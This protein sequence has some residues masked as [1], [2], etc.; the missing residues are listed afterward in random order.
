MNGCSNGICTSVVGLSLEARLSEARTLQDSSLTVM[1][2]K[3]VLMDQAL[4]RLNNV[5]NASGTIGAGADGSGNLS[6]PESLQ[7][8]ED[9]KKAREALMT[10][11][12]EFEGAKSYADQ[13]Q[14]FYDASLGAGWNA[15]APETTTTT[16]VPAPDALGLLAAQANAT[17]SAAAASLLLASASASANGS[18][19]VRS[20]LDKD[21]KADGARLE[22]EEAPILLLQDEQ[23]IHG[24]PDKKFT[25]ASSAGVAPMPPPSFAAMP[26]L[27]EDTGACASLG[28]SPVDIE[29]KLVIDPGVIS[30][31]L[32]ERLLFLQGD[33]SPASRLRVDAVQ[34]GRL[35]ISADVGQVAPFGAAL[36]EGLAREFAYVDVLSPGEHAVDGQAGAAEVQF[37]H[38]PPTSISSDGSSDSG[39]TA[40]AAAVA[41]SLRLEVG[42]ADNPWLEMLLSRVRGGNEDISPGA[43]G[44]S[45]LAEL[46]DFFRRGSADRYYRYDGSLTSLPCTRAQWLVL[47]EPGLVSQRQLRELQELSTGRQRGQQQPIRRFRASLVALGTTTLVSR[48]SSPTELVLPAPAAA[49]PM[50]A[51]IRLKSSQSSNSV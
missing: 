18:V 19:V 10:A 12:N 29:T 41:V 8:L 5:T 2:E 43:G 15:A 9:M 32:R 33:S 21:N 24:V 6:T 38:I 1:R 3:K 7:R 40:S 13:L 26:R 11:Q 39:A 22:A 30:P 20:S 37:I 45:M 25:A 35:R 51:R 49:P 50:L 17:S 31:E 16:L 34:D 47:A 44:L 42:P 14:V 23:K 48:S 46:H 36:V 4:L 27:R 28:L